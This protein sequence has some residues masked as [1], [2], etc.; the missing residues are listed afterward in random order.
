MNKQIIHE[1]DIAAQQE[2]KTFPQL[3]KGLLEAGVE[4]YSEDFGIYD[5]IDQ[6]ID[7]TCGSFSAGS[8]FYRR[9]IAKTSRGAR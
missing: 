1:L 8:S 5:H 2:M 3:V 4:S 7:D 9:G 6:A